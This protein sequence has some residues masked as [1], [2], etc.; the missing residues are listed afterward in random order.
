MNKPPYDPEALPPELRKL[1]PNNYH[2]RPVQSQHYS[3]LS[4]NQTDL[5]SAPKAVTPECKTKQKKQKSSAQ[6]ALCVAHSVRHKAGGLKSR[7]RKYG[8]R[9]QKSQTLGIRFRRGELSIIKTKALLAGVDTNSYIR[10]SALDS[11]YKQPMNPVLFEALHAANREL[12]M[13]GVN[14]NQI[15]KHMNSGQ[16]SLA[17]ADNLLGMIARSMFKTHKAVR[18]ALTGEKLWP[19]EEE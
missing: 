10:A 3:V 4:P 6:V 13:Q 19:D 18:Y 15:A 16:A 1:L 7:G 5:G 17:E 9:N 14:L 8:S 2:P 11:D 12:T